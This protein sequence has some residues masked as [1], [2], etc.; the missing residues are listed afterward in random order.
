MVHIV[1]SLVVD[2][3]FMVN[4]VEEFRIF[5]KGKFGFESWYHGPCTR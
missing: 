3:I 5:Y 1:V 2:P 4:G